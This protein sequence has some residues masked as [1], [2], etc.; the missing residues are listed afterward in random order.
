M[1]TRAFLVLAMISGGCALGPRAL[2]KT[3]GPYL[4]AVARVEEEQLLRNIVRVRYNEAPLVLNILS[5]TAQHEFSAGA[6]ARPF[7][8]TEATGNLFRSFTSVLPFVEAS[9]S[10]RPTFSFDPADD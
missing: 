2:E 5:V 1:R 9:A 6:E 7:F 3:H 10:A 4:D 8:S